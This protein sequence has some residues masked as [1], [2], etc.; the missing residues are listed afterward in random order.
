MMCRIVPMLGLVVAVAPGIAA[1]Q[2]IDHGALLAKRWCANCHVVDRTATEGRADGL[3]S[4]VA[5][6]NR[7][8]ATAESLRLT[9]TAE[10]GR[11]PNFS[12]SRPETNDLAAYILSLRSAPK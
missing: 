12:L 6:A 2:D 4:F 5:I 11:M 8:G 3:P 9:M 1:A 10:H 7:P